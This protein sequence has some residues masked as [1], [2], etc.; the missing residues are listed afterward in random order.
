[1]T[2]VDHFKEFLGFL[3]Y[4]SFDYK[5]DQPLDMRVVTI[6]YFMIF[7]IEM[8]LFIPVSSVLGIESMPHAM[9]AVMDDYTFL[10]VFILAVIIAP[11]AEELLFRLHLKYKP[12]IWLYFLIMLSSMFFMISGQ[13][14]VDLHSGPEI[15]INKLLQFAP[16]FASMVLIFLGYFLVPA[17]RNS[18]GSLVR[19]DFAAIFYI[20]AWVFAFVHIFNFELDSA[21]WYLTPLLVLPQFILALYLG[22][23]RV[24]NTIFHSMYVHALNNCIPL[25]LLKIATSATGIQ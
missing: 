18:I 5:S 15:I 19:S 1:M 4:P 10:Q 8:L 20:T 12:L 3:R 13:A 16:F 21:N 11:I 9:E 2:I 22:Y 7:A 14:S 17:I 23:I 6:L 24:R 25:M